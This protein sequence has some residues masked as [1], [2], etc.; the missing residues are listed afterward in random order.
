MLLTKPQAMDV[1]KTFPTLV[2][3]HVRKATDEVVTQR[4]LESMLADAIDIV[5]D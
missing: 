2:R 4:Q 5:K 1:A 3:A